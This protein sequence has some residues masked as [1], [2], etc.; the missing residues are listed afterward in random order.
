MSLLAP[1]RRT[2]RLSDIGLAEDRSSSCALRVVSIASAQPSGVTGSNNDS[3]AMSSDGK[4]V[5]WAP[6]GTTAAY[7][8]TN[9]TSGKPAW[10]AVTG[11]PAQASV[12]A[13]RV[14]GNKFYGFSN[15]TF[16]VSTDG[17]ATFVPSP[18]ILPSAASAYFKAVPGHEGDIWF[19]A[20][21]SGL[22]H[23]VDSGQ[24]FTQ[25]TQVAAAD[26]IGFGMAAPQQKY[27]ALYSS[28]HVQGVA[29]IYRSD[30][31][32][33]TW[34]RINN[35]NQN[36]YGSTSAAITGDPRVYGRVYL[37]TNGRGIIYG[38]INMGP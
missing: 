1:N 5:V 16:Y 6:T 2:K 25:I 7:T 19:A 9:W 28:A 38:D 29:G 13:D 17:G 30:D 35:N 8:S 10:A 20:G 23:S 18:A 15:G 14:T 33:V 12:R 26:N 24:S 31:G 4:R 21:S 36:Q 11:L 32:G 3:I 37:A 27:V 22:W 34:V